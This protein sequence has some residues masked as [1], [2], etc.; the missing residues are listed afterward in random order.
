MR[1]LALK[2]VHRFLSAKIEYGYGVKGLGLSYQ[3]DFKKTVPC[4]KCGEPSRI[5]VVLQETFD[6]AKTPSEQTFVTRLHDNDPEGDG[7]WPHDCAAF[8]IY[9]CPEIDCGTAT[10]IWNQA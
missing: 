9:V 3:A 8:A 4:V 6:K 10:T 7:F 5:A 2:V 1:S